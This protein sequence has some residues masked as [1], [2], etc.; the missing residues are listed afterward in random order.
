L[1][2]LVIAHYR[3]DARVRAI[4]VF[5]SVSTGTWHDLSDV[6]LDV[7]TEDGAVIEPASEATALFGPRAVIILPRTDSV[8][9]VLDSLEEVSIRWHPLA[10]TSPNICASAQ[11]VAG[12]LSTAE[13]V[14]AGDGN[15]VQPDEQQ[16]L[17]AFVRDAVY[18]WKAINRA[19]RWDAVAA[20]QRMRQS[21]VGLCG[22]RDSLRL[23]PADPAGALSKVIAEAA[24]RSI[25]GRPGTCSLS[26][27]AAASSQRDEAIRAGPHRPQTVRITRRTRPTTCH[28]G[29]WRS[30]AGRILPLV[31][32][33]RMDACGK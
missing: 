21:L 13:I 29:W 25:S 23:D 4:V 16:L 26:D 6:D 24:G 28:G 11:V 32:P 27:S 12:D 17:D 14:A 7:V 5:G 33:F 2:E 18:A 22:R 9:V 1:I 19:N 30:L 10:A 15:R 31:G 8:D 20:V 3:G